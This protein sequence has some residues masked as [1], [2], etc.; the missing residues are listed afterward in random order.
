MSKNLSQ[1][2]LD[3]M[4]KFWVEKQS[5]QFVASS[6]SVSR[7]TVRKYRQ[8]LK[9]DTRLFNIQQDAQK[10]QDLSIAEALAANIKFAQYIK[11]KLIKRIKAIDDAMFHS[12][13]FV[14]DFDKIVRLEMFLRGEADSRTETKPSALKD[15]PTSEL[16]RM[17]RELEKG[18]G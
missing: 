4:F 14:S 18:K 17:K 5:I 3:E 11:G 16:L 1:K 6:C 13:N 10:K 2:T 12:T 9:W 15:V 8:L 7:V